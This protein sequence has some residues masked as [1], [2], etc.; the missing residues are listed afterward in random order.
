[1]SV[2]VALA[3][4]ALSAGAMPVAARVF[5]APRPL[6]DRALLAG[7]IALAAPIACVRALS[8][9]RLLTPVAMLAAIVA[10]SAAAIALAGGAARTQAKRDAREAAR[11][12]GD[13][14]VAGTAAPLAWIGVG[15][16]ALA[17]WAA[18]RFAPWA[19]DAL[20][21]HL[22]IVLD[23]VATRTLRTV[24][25][26]VPYVN[27]Y[28]RAVETY[29]VAARL[30]L[31]DDAWIDFAQAPFG[32]LGA[33]GVAAFARRLGAPAARA[34][35]FGLAFLAVPLVVL[36]LAADYVDVAVA[37]LLAASVYFVSAPRLEPR[38]LAAWAL[39]TG[40]F[41]GSKP[42]APPVAALL[43]LVAL[44]RAPRL[45]TAAA[46]AGVV[47]IGGESYVANLVAH[48]NPIWPIALDVGPFHLPGEDD[49]GPLFVHGLPPELQ[50]ASWLRR[51]AVSLF[52]E[53]REYIYDMRLGG[54]GP[55]T[56]IALVPLA[57]V[58]AVRRRWAAAPALLLAAC[59]LASPAAHWM[60]YSLALP[61]ALLALTAVATDSQGGSAGVLHARRPIEARH[62]RVVADVAVAALAV[63]GLLRAYPGLVAGAS[64]VD[65]HEAQWDTVRAKVGAGEAFA[66]DAS[67][68]LPG[69]L[70]CADG[71]AGPAVYL[72]AART[73]DDVDRAMDD[74]HVRVVVAGDATATAEAV[75]RSRDAYTLAFRCPMDPCTVFVRRDVAAELVAR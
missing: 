66:Y 30:L 55:M 45:G 53:P 61:V 46:C 73:A 12:A 70:A 34:A 71:R 19:W 14:F 29:F 52:V 26:H 39:A 23:A 59:A 51:V 6:R 63:V 58:A 56:A 41:L 22:P 72:G 7:V 40:L 65:G 42:S 11:I 75:Q 50:H 10:L 25:T 36:Q 20:G 69:Q 49:A 28:P 8:P 2:A 44:A 31:G 48:G 54:L 60:R 62:G 37:A 38:D 18:W 16:L 47:A 15:A 57:F 3:A 67:F 64:G 27:A 35:A 9:L 17:G 13:A 74:G 1:V 43:C 68:E 24:P 5:P 33:V 4:V 32:L 21:Y